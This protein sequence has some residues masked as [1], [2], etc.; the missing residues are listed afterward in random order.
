MIFFNSKNYGSN[1]TVP[2]Q[3]TCDIKS[4]VGRPFCKAS[5]LKCTLDFEIVN[6][7][8]RCFVNDFEMQDVHLT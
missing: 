2:S 6:S 4:L 7:Y 1:L 8:F 3:N 5:S